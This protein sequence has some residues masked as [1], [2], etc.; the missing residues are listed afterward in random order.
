MINT[1]MNK[2]CLAALLMAG[3]SMAGAGTSLACRIYGV[4]SNNLPGG[5]LQSH[6]ITEPNSIKNLSKEKNQDGWSVAY[7]INFGKS[8]VIERGA[9]SAYNS[10]AY[11]TAVTGMADTYPN[12]ALAHIRSC[13]SGCCDPN[14][15]TIPNPHPFTRVK[16]N[17][18]W[19][20]IHNGFA[21]IPVLTE[22]IGEKYL[23]SNPPD[24]SGIPQCNPDNP[25]NI[26]DSEL[27]F[28][29]LLKNIEAN[30]WSVVNGIVDTVVPLQAYYLNFILTD[31][32]TVWAY[33]KGF[34]LCYSYDAQRGVSAITSQPPS[35]AREHW[36]Y[37]ENNELVIATAHKAPHIINL[38]TCGDGVV[39]PY[40]TCDNNNTDCDLTR[41]Q[42]W[43]CNLR[44]CQCEL[45]GDVNYDETI[46]W[47]DAVSV[48]NIASGKGAASGDPD[49]NGD[50]AV[51]FQDVLYVMSKM[52][53]W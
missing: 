6:L 47:Q 16:N 43:K 38:S 39:D 18:T 37:L 50:G 3:V 17:R 29:L 46:N 26:V 48:L 1:G 51:N 53:V 21:D 10:Q 2:V 24:G 4:I 13:S 8:P 25:D 11:D 12:I 35:A 28:L 22:L 23:N 44:T 45:T 7:Y 33:R 5:I 27:L 42:N 31:G 52:L 15:H 49:C 40:E 32:Y 14:N 9:E 34:E 30:S 41:G 20:F 36:I 19:L